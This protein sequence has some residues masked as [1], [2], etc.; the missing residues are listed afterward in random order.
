MIAIMKN[1]DI[2]VP[3]YNA[4]EYTEECIKSL[5]KYTN[6][7]EHAVLLI[8]DKSPD[9]RIM[10]MLQKYAD[11]NKDK[12][13]IVL[14]NETNSGFVKTV[15]IGMQYSKN[16]I[17][18]L[19]SDTEV[20]EN[21]LEK[22]QIAAYSNE[23]IATVTPLTNNGTIASV[24]N[25]GIDNELPQNISMEEY[26]Q[27]IENCSLRRYPEVTT[28]NGFCMYIKRKVI[29]EIGLF[30]DITFEKGYG[31]ENDFCY[32][33]LDYGYTN[34]LCDDTFI[35][36][37]GTQSFKKENLT[38]SRVEVIES[39]MKKLRKKYPIYT[40]K[41]DQF[42]GLNPLRDIQENI[43][44]NTITYK[45]K[46]I[47]FLVNEW[48]ENMEMTGGTSLHLKDII[49]GIKKDTACL[50]LCPEKN[51]LTIFNLY[52]YV[53]GYGKKI[54]HFKTDMNLYGQITY[55]NNS[56]KEMLETIIDSFQIDLLHVHHFLF[57]GFDVIDIAKKRNIYSIITLHDLYMSCP[58][59]NMIY[60][61]KFCENNERKDCKNCLKHYYGVENDILHNWR[62]TC[63]ETLKKFDKIIVPSYNTKKYF[64][65]IYPELSIDVIEHGAE[66][67][68][69]NNKKQKENKNTFNIAFVGAM[70]PHK[71]S[72]ILKALIKQNTNYNIK[73]HLF[74]K[75]NDNEL[76]KSKKNYINHGPYKRGELP[77]LL[78]DNQIDLVCMF[79]VWPETY[80]YTLTE[81]YM[82]K[83][84]VLSFKIGAVGDRI[85]KDNLGWTIA[86]SS[87]IEEIQNKII[88]IFNNKEDYENKKKNFEN[89]KFKNIE[90]M[91]K[92]YRTIYQKNLQDSNEKVA[93]VK[94]VLKLQKQS[95]E[96]EYEQYRAQYM[97]I[98]SKYER[99]R[100]TKI[101][102]IA[103][104]IKNKTKNM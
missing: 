77:K 101:W 30:D 57:N 20:T 9:E 67:I 66:F 102:E 43:R 1:V 14:E 64:E 36:H 15:N 39:H 16:D 5:L 7:H 10:P 65:K 69:V 46:R 13:I 88:E 82:S 48:E 85:E 90:E 38:K 45:K 83:V 94:N 61:G 95:S 3:I 33:A 37:K 98:I 54:A 103:K 6:L 96:Q 84:P 86:L 34:I 99:I 41:T 31:E 32:R 71:G 42:L 12:N 75:P 21:W 73:I 70:A 49:N 17:I 80:S 89:Y 79:A 78:V 59:I 2:V 26:A 68:E 52:L 8:N 22:I 93:K 56:Y 97:H 51:D 18:L 29:D 58:S 92:E 104:K 23:Y 25:F 47:L 62:N 44:I 91:Q 24:P 50:V 72:N 100:N 81:T 19:N 4:Y 40:S 76:A 11:E 74:G 87:S 35:Y 53:Q 55:T 60:N 63:Y 27:I 28:G